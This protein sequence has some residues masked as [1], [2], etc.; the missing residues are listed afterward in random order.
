MD[1]KPK[2]RFARALINQRWKRKSARKKHA[3]TIRAYWAQ[4]SEAER[5]EIMRKRN[6]GGAKAL[7]KGLSDSTSDA[8]RKTP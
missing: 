2:N 8:P 3:E 5:K 1:D 7:H 6:M 4:F